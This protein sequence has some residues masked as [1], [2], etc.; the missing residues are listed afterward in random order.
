METP[1]P[2]PGICVEEPDGI[3]IS[4]DGTV[5]SAAGFAVHESVK[6]GAYPAA[7]LLGDGERVHVAP[8]ITLPDDLGLGYLLVFETVRRRVGCRRSVPPTDPTDVSPGDSVL[9]E[10]TFERSQ[11]EQVP[12]H[13]TDV[14]ERLGSDDSEPIDEPPFRDRLHIFTLGVTRM[15]EA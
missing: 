3:D 10:V 6:E 9:G 14:E 7:D 12:Q 2:I 11:L 13:P 4:V 5:A 1:Y 8:N 15:I